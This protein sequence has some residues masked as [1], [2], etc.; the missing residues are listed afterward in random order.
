MKYGR[1]IPPFRETV[2]YVPK[3]L[4]Y[5]RKVRPTLTDG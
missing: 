1:R 3:V 2:A 4:G 5:Y